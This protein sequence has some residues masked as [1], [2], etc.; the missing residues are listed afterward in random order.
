M[1]HTQ[2]RVAFKEHKSSQQRVGHAC[3]VGPHQKS[4]LWENSLH[5]SRRCWWAQNIAQQWLEA[6]KPRAQLWQRI[7]GL[8]ESGGVYQLQVFGELAFRCDI[9]W[10]QIKQS[11][12]SNNSLYHRTQCRLYSSEY[13]LMVGWRLHSTSPIV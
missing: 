7:A 11:L 2:A 13:Q 6:R 1:N 5:R 4:T 9:F 3:P 8:T 10:K 12:N